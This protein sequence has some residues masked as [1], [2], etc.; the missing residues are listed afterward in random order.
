MTTGNESASPLAS[1]V[2]GQSPRSPR[3]PPLWPVPGGMNDTQDDDLL[4]P[5]GRD[6]N[7]IRNDIRPASD[8]FLVSVRNP[9]RPAC[10]RPAQ[11]ITSAAQLG[12]HAASGGRIASSDVGDRR[13]KL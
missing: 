4:A 1:I 13:F 3:P 10:G 8:C 6:V 7:R 5:V 9:S 2:P 11:A 12:N